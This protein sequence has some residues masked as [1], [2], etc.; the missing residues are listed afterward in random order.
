MLLHACLMHVS[1]LA[2]RDARR[3]QPGLG[4]AGRDTGRCQQIPGDTG[5]Y[6]EIPGDTGRGSEMPDDST[7]TWSKRRSDARAERESAASAPPTKHNP[8]SGLRLFLKV[9]TRVRRS[10]DGGGRASA[11]RGRWDGAGEGAGWRL[12][13]GCSGGRA[14]SGGCSAQGVCVSVCVRVWVRAVW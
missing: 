9:L 2:L 4:D 13:C 11:G 12:V 3:Y 7:S 5:R 1:G 8:V 10:R 6:R 14:C